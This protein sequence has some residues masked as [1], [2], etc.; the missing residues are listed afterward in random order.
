M[1]SAY[2]FD[3]DM[4]TSHPTD[5]GSRWLWWKDDLEPRP[6]CG[7]PM[8]EVERWNIGHRCFGHCTWTVPIMTCAPETRLQTHHNSHRIFLQERLLPICLSTVN[9]LRSSGL[10]QL[11]NLLLCSDLWDLKICTFH[12][13]TWTAFWG[14]DA[15]WIDE[16]MNGRTWLSLVWW[17]QVWNIV[18]IPSLQRFPCRWSISLFR[19]EISSLW[20]TGLQRGR[21]FCLKCTSKIQPTIYVFQLRINATYFSTHT[22]TS[23][24]LTTN[25]R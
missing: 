22:S 15:S 1:R 25:I 2:D 3:V 17:F 16:L 13:C 18:N 23:N 6:P 21:V 11:P 8:G 9:H 10:P 24:D 7:A 20:S 5:L 14:K 19:A 4:G 12:F